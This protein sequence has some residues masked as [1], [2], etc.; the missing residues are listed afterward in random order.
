MLKI[1]QKIETKVVDFNG[2]EKKCTIHQLH[3]EEDTANMDP[4]WRYEDWTY[5]LN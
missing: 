2:E 4:D 3:L 1:G 5:S